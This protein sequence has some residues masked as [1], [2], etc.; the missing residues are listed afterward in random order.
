MNDF[1]DYQPKTLE[2]YSRFIEQYEKA[3]DF[4]VLPEMYLVLRVDSHRF[5][6]LWA[7]H[8]DAEYPLGEKFA[9]AYVSTAADLMRAGFRYVFALCH[10]DEISLLFHSSEAINPRRRSNLHSLVSS[11]AALSFNQHYGLPVLFHSKLSEL[12]T[13]RHVLDYF[14]FMRRTFYRNLLSQALLRGLANE[15]LSRQDINKKIQPL[16]NPERLALAESL[17]FRF[18]DCPAWLKYGVGLWWDEQANADPRLIDSWHLPESDEDY[19]TLLLNKIDGT[20]YSCQPEMQEVP[21]RTIRQPSEAT[22][23]KVADALRAPSPTA[24]ART[25]QT[26]ANTA[27]QAAHK[28]H[29]T[30]ATKT[31]KESNDAPFRV[32]NPKSGSKL[33]PRRRIKPQKS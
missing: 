3:N 27:L 25:I 13:K 7:E 21:R 18:E 2:E 6:P 26:G 32:G 5:G 22:A 19:L 14:F 9:Q 23:K 11:A 29:N 28:S 10:G 12:P 17:G 30:S 33:M 1:N 8:N 16:G 4:L 15:G 31:E 20:T 24:P